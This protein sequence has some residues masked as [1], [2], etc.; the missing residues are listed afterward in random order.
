MPSASF[1]WSHSKKLALSTRKCSLF[2]ISFENHAKSK[3]TFGGID[4]DLNAKGPM[5]W[6]DTTGD[7]MWEIN[8]KG[9]N[10]N[11]QELFEGGKM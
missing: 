11:G 6:H 7:V 5:H 4:L 10:F 9:A 3:V 2:L 1:T 8:M